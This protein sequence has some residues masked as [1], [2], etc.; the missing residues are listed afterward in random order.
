MWI[1]LFALRYKYTIGVLG[2]L[3]D[4]AFRFL[5]MTLTPWAKQ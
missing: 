1:V 2:I 3:T 5:R 4:Q